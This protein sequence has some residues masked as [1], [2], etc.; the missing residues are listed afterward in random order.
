MNSI[1]KKKA[2]SVQQIQCLDKTAIEK[3]GIPAI[4]LMGLLRNDP[5]SKNKSNIFPDDKVS[6]LRYFLTTI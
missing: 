3:Y 6:I 5:F 1:I 2:V 4:V